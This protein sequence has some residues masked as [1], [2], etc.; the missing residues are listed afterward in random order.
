MSQ[1]IDICAAAD[2][3]PGQRRL[4][5]VGDDDEVLVLHIDGAYYAISNVCP[6]AGAA[7]ERGNVIDGVLFCPLHQWGFRLS[8]G[9]SIAGDGLQACIYRIISQGERLYLEWG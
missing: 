2:L 1:F 9:R 5:D 6:H 8:N 3:A 7:L 4:V